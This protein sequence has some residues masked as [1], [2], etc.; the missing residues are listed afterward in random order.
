MKTIQQYIQNISKN[1]IALHPEQ[2]TEA[3]IKEQYIGKAPATED[4]IS[5]TEKRLGIALPKDVIEF[6]KISNGTLELCKQTFGDFTA[7]EKIE[8]L[9][10]IQ[11]ETIEAYAGMGEAYEANLNNSILLAGENH[12]HQILLIQPRGDKKDWQYWEFAAYIPGENSFK[13]IENYL[14]RIDDFLK[15][16]IVEKNK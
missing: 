13:G 5:A 12:P 6:Y 14:E 16:Q 9:K 2:Y 15:N 7:I 8:W 11:P 3:E 1:A 4:A 10:K